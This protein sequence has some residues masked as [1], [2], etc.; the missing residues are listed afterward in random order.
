MLHY[1]FYIQGEKICR[2]KYPGH[3]KWAACPPY[4]PSDV[5]SVLT[6]N[7]LVENLRSFSIWWVASLCSC[8]LLH[9]LFWGC[10]GSCSDSALI[11]LLCCEVAQLFFL[12]LFVLLLTSEQCCAFGELCSLQIA[13]VCGAAAHVLPGCAVGVHD[14]SSFSS[15]C[16]WGGIL[17]RVWLGLFY[18]FLWICVSSKFVKC[19]VSFLCS[20]V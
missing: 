4:P 11:L 5:A 7:L 20:L 18:C 16:S 10:S 13:C 3:W 14:F 1:D 19:F 15:L 17:N 9:H 12:A 8:K 6:E 2:S